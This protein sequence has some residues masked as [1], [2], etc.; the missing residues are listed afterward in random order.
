MKNFKE[1]VVAVIKSIKHGETKSYSEVA[2]LSGNPRAF[3]AVG[4]ICKNNQ[5]KSIPCHRVVKKSGEVGSYNGLLG[6]SK[7]E[8]LKREAKRNYSEK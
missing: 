6:K 3:R 8:V 4:T 1:R 5:D 2:R 7:I